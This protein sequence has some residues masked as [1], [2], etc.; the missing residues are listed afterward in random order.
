[1]YFEMITLDLE[2]VKKLKCT[3]N[4]EKNTRRNFGS[5]KAIVCLLHKLAEGIKNKEQPKLMQIG[6]ETGIDWRENI[7]YQGVHG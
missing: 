3:W 2:D 5:E 7:Y 4:A 6:K 1:M